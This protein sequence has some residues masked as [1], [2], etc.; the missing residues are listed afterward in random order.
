MPFERV[1]HYYLSACALLLARPTQGR[2][3]NDKFGM[4]VFA[5]RCIFSSTEDR[6]TG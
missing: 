5:T 3:L 6:T 4:G 2:F 1:N